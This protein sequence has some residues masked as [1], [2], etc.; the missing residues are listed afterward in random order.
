MIRLRRTF[1]LPTRRRCPAHEKPDI[2]PEPTGREKYHFTGIDEQ[3]RQE[4]PWQQ[5]LG[6]WEDVPDE[7]DEKYNEECRAENPRFFENC[8]RQE[9][10]FHW[11]AERQ[12]SQRLQDGVERGV[13]G[14]AEAN[15][16]QWIG[17]EGNPLTLDATSSGTLEGFCDSRLAVAL[18]NKAEDGFR[19]QRRLQQEEG[20]NGKREKGADRFHHAFSDG[21]PPLGAAQQ[22]HKEHNDKAGNDSDQRRPSRRQKKQSP[23]CWGRCIQPRS[24]PQRRKQ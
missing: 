5:E 15:P 14:Y 8:G 22:S 3:A 21:L 9:A 12:S 24:S 11:R 18:A 2:K 10:F 20:K 7:A 6:F 4:D 23:R 13:E 1:A 16:V 17:I 19:K